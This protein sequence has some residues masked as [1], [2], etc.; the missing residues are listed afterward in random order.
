MIEVTRLNGKPFVINAVLI[1]T[2]EETP[3]TIITLTNGKK[4]I[5][6]EKQSEVISLVI[7]Y[8]RH[9]GSFQI[10]VKS[11]DLEESHD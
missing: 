8:M 9:I 6:R 2:V 7:A 1:E 10:S 11:Q 3:D 5:V 4:Y